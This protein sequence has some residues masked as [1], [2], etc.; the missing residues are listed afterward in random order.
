MT[1]MKN[2]KFYNDLF[3]SYRSVIFVVRWK[4]SPLLKDCLFFR[5]AVELCFAL[6]NSSNIRSMAKELINFLE[7]CDV[8]LKGYVTSNLI[9]VAEK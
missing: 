5:R 4:V 2:E 1:I 9:T 6:V 8:E 3:T 7:R